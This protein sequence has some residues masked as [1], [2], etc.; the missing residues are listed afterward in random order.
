MNLFL[1]KIQKVQYRQNTPWSS[2]STLKTFGDLDFSA[3]VHS[4]ERLT[5]W[6]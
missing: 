2:L 6:Q 1:G 4:G 5:K 3:R